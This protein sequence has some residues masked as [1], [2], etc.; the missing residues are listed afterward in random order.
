MIYIYFPQTYCI[1]TG[2]IRVLIG[3]VFTRLPHSHRWR[4]LQRGQIQSA[5]DFGESPRTWKNVLQDFPGPST[6]GSILTRVGVSRLQ[7]KRIQPSI[8]HEKNKLQ[9]FYIVLLFPFCIICL[10]I[11]NLKPTVYSKVHFNTAMLFSFF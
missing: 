3:N 1:P 4:L 6:H 2:Q 11:W 7:I 10:S 8:N 5:G 9:T